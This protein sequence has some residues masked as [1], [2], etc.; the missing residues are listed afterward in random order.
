MV[1]VVPVIL[2]VTMRLVE[3]DS[4]LKT[5]ARYIAKSKKVETLVLAEDL[6][7]FYNEEGFYPYRVIRRYQYSAFEP[8][9]DDETSCVLGTCFEE[10]ISDM[11][12]EEFQRGGKAKPARPWN[13]VWRTVYIKLETNEERTNFWAGS[14]MVAT[15]GSTQPLE[16]DFWSSAR[17]YYNFT[18]PHVVDSA[19]NMLLIFIVTCI[20]LAFALELQKVIGRIVLNPLEEL[21]NQVRNLASTMFQS[22][23]DMSSAMKAQEDAEKDGGEGRNLIGG[24]V[25]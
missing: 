25:F 13:E 9:W 21:L 12:V 19:M 11:E 10:Q 16:Q 17:I 7:D 1:I 20:L 23:V 3:Q 4:G 6:A 8:D 22:V 15:I 24:L 18:Q 14:N 2:V 5:W